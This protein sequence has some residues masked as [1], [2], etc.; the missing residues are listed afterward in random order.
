VLLLVNEGVSN[1][2]EMALVSDIQWI[3]NPTSELQRQKVVSIY[4]RRN[5]LAAMRKEYSLVG[6]GELFKELEVKLPNLVVIRSLIVKGKEILLFSD[7]NQ[8]QY[9]GYIYVQELRPSTDDSD[10]K[11]QPDDGQHI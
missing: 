10:H 11:P 5:S 1:P 8:E 9:Y 7:P 2:D 4:M 6:I 3:S